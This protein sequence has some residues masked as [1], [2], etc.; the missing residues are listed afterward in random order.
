ML[1]KKENAI[2]RENDKGKIEELKL[3]GYK[4]VKEE[5]LKKEA[6]KANKAAEKAKKEEEDKKQ[7][8]K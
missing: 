4:E 6:E 8:D 3:A 7:G 5:D 1:L 2:L